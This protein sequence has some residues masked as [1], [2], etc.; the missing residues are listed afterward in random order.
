MLA[1]HRFGLAANGSGRRS[2][3]FGF[4]SPQGRHRKRPGVHSASHDWR[5]EEFARW[6]DGGELDT[7]CDELGTFPHWY[8]IGT[9]EPVREPPHEDFHTCSSE[10]GT[11][12]NNVMS[13]FAGSCTW[14][15]RQDGKTYCLKLTCDSSVLSNCENCK[16][17]ARL[18]PRT[19]PYS[20]VCVHWTCL[21]SYRMQ[22]GLA[23]QGG[24][25]GYPPAEVRSQVEGA[26]MALK[27]SQWMKKGQCQGCTT[28]SSWFF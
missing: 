7:T 21:A 12:V 3:P 10:D 17:P 23:A 19:S 24:A 26:A 14:W 11:C 15:F 8:E 5:H 9:G 13:I 28:I 6:E 16:P 1:E 22:V 18:F 25:I 27:G 4:G 20:C 2:F